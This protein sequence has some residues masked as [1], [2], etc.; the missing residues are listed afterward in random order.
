[1]FELSYRRKIEIL[2][3][4]DGNFDEQ[5][6]RECA[7]YPKAGAFGKPSPCLNCKFDIPN[8]ECERSHIL[9]D[10]RLYGRL[11]EKCQKLYRLRP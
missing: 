10:T 5:L 2:R 4:F 1:M 9:E 7:Y 8:K 11:W 3:I 6:L